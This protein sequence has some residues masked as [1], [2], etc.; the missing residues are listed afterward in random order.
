MCHKHCYCV[1]ECFQEGDAVPAWAINII[2][3]FTAQEGIKGNRTNQGGR[4][5]TFV[6]V[7]VDEG[8]NKQEHT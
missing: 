8:M 1:V 5:S 3:Q 7:R 4:V 2:E 6:G